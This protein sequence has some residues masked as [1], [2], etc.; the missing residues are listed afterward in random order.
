MNP[1]TLLKLYV[2]FLLQ[3]NCNYEKEKRITK[4]L[5]Y[6]VLSN[7]HM[8]YKILEYSSHRLG[9]ASCEDILIILNTPPS[10]QKKKYILG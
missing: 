10:K 5:F 4:I 3:I 9:I 8:I 7:I 6:N 1:T 2:F